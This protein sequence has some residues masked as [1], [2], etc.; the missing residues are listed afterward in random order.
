MT[1]AQLNHFSLLSF[2]RELTD[3]LDY[4]EIITIFN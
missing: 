2:E 3:T 1:S 4:D